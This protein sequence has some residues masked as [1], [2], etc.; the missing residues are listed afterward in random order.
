MMRITFVC[1]QCFMTVRRE[2]PAGKGNAPQGGIVKCPRGHGEM[3][4]Q[5]LTG[6]LRKKKR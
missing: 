4:N 6:L 2:M 1:P 3:L 5:Y